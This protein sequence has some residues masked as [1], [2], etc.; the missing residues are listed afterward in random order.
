[1]SKTLATLAALATTLLPA[2]VLAQ[3]DTASAGYSAGQ[4]TGRVFVVLVL[5]AVGSKVVKAVRA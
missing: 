2:V 4:W 5:F 3:T 1:M